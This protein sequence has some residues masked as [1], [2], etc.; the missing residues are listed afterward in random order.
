MATAVEVE[1]VL[2][3]LG[4]TSLEPLKEEQE[5]GIEETIMEKQVN[6]LN[7]TLVNFFKGVVSN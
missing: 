6:A 4:E 3:E 5:E 2:G 1:R 7:E